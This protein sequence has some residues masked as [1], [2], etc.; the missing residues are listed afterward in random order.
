MK[1]PPRFVPIVNNRD[2]SRLFVLDYAQTLMA[3]QV[4]DFVHNEK[5]KRYDFRKSEF[6]IRIRLLADWVA[7]LDELNMQ[8]EYYGDWDS[9]K[10]DINS[11]NRLIIIA[12]EKMQ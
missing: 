8:A 6:K 1:N 7:I 5:E 3:V 11:G 9:A 2:I 10:Y 12:K 4:F